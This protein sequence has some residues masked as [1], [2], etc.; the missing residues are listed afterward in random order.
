M[1][2]VKD[3]GTME[4]LSSVLMKANSDS[5]DTSRCTVMDAREPLLFAVRIKGCRL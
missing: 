1:P 3:A 4:A 2:A 5:E